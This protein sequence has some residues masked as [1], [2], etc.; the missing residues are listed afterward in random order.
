MSSSTS[1]VAIGRTLPARTSSQRRVIQ[2]DRMDYSIDWSSRERLAPAGEYR[3]LRTPME[4]FPG[5]IAGLL[6]GR[7]NE[8]LAIGFSSGGIVRSCLLHEGE[9]LSVRPLLS[10]EELIA[11]AHEMGST[12]LAFIHNHPFADRVVV[13]TQPSGADLACADYLAVHALPLGISVLGIICI[14]GTPHEFYWRAP[15]P[16]PQQTSFHTIPGFSS[17]PRAQGAP[18]RSEDGRFLARRSP[19]GKAGHWPRAE[20]CCE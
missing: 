9:A 5:W 3:Q 17:D 18:N 20:T 2:P 8:W 12:E 16:G 4:R 19:W 15:A 11:L 14:D 7:S 1:A 10:W 13:S 6:H